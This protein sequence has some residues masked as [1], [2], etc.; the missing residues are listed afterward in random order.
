MEAREPDKQA[1]VFYFASELSATLH[2]LLSCRGMARAARGCECV[3]MACLHLWLMWVGAGEDGGSH[4][5]CYCP[6]RP[7]LLLSAASAWLPDRLAEVQ[8]GARH[9]LL[10]PCF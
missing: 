1:S 2:Y 4:V 8:H 3:A 10:Q 6:S 9:H 7:D 5:G